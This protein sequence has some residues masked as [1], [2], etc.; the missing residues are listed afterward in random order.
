MGCCICQDDKT[1][2]DTFDDYLYE[3][4]DKDYKSL[5]VNDRLTYSSEETN[6][7]I[8]IYKLFHID[9]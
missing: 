9:Y 6:N 5:E 3:N 8:Y 7:Y 2:V 1:S 4:D